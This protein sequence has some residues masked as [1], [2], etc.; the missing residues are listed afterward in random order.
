VSVLMPREPDLGFGRPNAHASLLQSV[1]AEAPSGCKDYA[2][3][4]KTAFSM[5][6][7]FQSVAVRNLAQVRADI[8]EQERARLHG[9]VVARAD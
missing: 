4:C 2:G 9:E 8:E 6:D 3:A 7:S 5:L 1:S